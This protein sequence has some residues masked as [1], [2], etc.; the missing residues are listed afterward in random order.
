[1]ILFWGHKE[2]TFYKADRADRHGAMKRARRFAIDSQAMEFHYVNYKFVKEE[3][4]QELFPLNSD[5]MHSQLIRLV[6]LAIELALTPFSQFS[7]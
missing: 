1:M 4:W 2:L 5:D 6:L 3:L 7:S